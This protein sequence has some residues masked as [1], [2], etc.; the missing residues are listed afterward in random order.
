MSGHPSADHFR[1]QLQALKRSKE[2]GQLA[3]LPL[4]IEAHHGKPLRPL[5]SHFRFEGHSRRL[6][7]DQLLGSSKSSSSSLS[8]ADRK[9]ATSFPTI[10]AS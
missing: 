10:G 3:N 8:T 6:T 9:R 1:D 2:D 4:L 5:A 7:F